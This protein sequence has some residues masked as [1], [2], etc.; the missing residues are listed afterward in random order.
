MIGVPG[1]VCME[2]PTE[3]ASPPQPKGKRNIPTY[4][5]SAAY[6]CMDTTQQ[7]GIRYA[8]AKPKNRS[9]SLAS[10]A[11]GQML[12]WQGRTAVAAAERRQ[13]QH[14]TARRQ[15]AVVH[16]VWGNSS[17]TALPACSSWEVDSKINVVCMQH[18][19]AQ[20][21]PDHLRAPSSCLN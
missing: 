20:H 11:M 2:Q 12:A 16:L 6:I 10:I 17:T 5:S 1:H 18:G 9:R 15:R 13:A 3:H 21:M 19:D 7:E 14:R 4:L 8:S